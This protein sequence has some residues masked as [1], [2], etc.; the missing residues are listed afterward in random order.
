[1]TTPDKS[2]EL[3]VSLQLVNEKLHFLG[4]NGTHEPVS[5]DYFPPAGD[6]L[7]HTSL[8]LFLLSLASCAGSAILVILR[9][10]GKTVN[11]LHIRANGLRRQEHPTCFSEIILD[12]ELVSADTLETDLD[13]AVALAEERLC[14]VWAMVK[15]NVPV[16]VVRRVTTRTAP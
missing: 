8:E 3:E 5:I 4:S 2:R 16:R 1:M 14:P 7:G 10:T 13:R 6:H 15:G 12:L 11:G 9:K